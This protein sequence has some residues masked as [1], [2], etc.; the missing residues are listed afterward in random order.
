MVL[1]D[2]FDGTALAPAAGDRT[3]R[4]HWFWDGDRMVAPDPA[5]VDG[6]EVDPYPHAFPAGGSWTRRPVAG[7][8]PPDA[9]TDEAPDGWGVNAAGGHWVATYGQ[10]YSTETAETS[11]RCRS[12]RARS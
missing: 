10:V 11:G 8:P 2:V 3:A 4:Q 9:L 12:P 1:A 7:A 5:T 6:G